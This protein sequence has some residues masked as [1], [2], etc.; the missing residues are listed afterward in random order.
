MLRVR[1]VSVIRATRTYWQYGGWPARLGLS[2]NAVYTTWF[3]SMLFRD[4]SNQETTIVVTAYLAQLGIVYLGTK[5]HIEKLRRRAE[6][7][8][9]KWSPE[10]QE[11]FRA[12]L[13][14]HRIQPRDDH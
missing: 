6:E 10:H 12:F 11:E 8:V 13:E 9:S 2:A 7:A 3:V 4:V 14:R 1:A 5:R